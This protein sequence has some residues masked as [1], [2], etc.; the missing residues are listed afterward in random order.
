MSLTLKELTDLIGAFGT[1]LASLAAFFAINT[2]RSKMNL[3]LVDEFIITLYQYENAILELRRPFSTYREFARNRGLFENLIVRYQTRTEQL[4]S[5]K[6]AFNKARIK[7]QA[8][9]GDF[10]NMKVCHLF[11]YEE[12]IQAQINILLMAEDPINKTELRREYYAQL[13]RDILYA[14]LLEKDDRFAIDIKVQAHEIEML[15]RNKLDIMQSI[16]NTFYMPAKI[17]RKFMKQIFRN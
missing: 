7:T 10:I 12:Q 17:V 5:T 11:F 4:N 16:K 3:E 1:C 9:W 13:D 2:W 14:K 8:R 6:A 15:I